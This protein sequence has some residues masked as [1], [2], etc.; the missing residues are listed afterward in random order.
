VGWVPLAPYEPYYPWYGRGYYG[1]YR[2]GYVDRSVHVT[3]VNIVNVYRNARVRD[4]ISGVDAGSFGRGRGNIARVSAEQI[5]EAGLVRGQLPVAP[6]HES[7]RYANHEARY[8]PREDANTRFYSRR[9]PAAVERVS[10]AEQQRSFDPQARRAAQGVTAQPG[11]VV[12]PAE[13]AGSAR[14]NGWRRTGDA[15]AART[16]AQPGEAVRRNEPADRGDGNWRRVGERTARPET[17]VPA[18]AQ[19][20]GAEQQVRRNEPADRTNGNWRRFGD[21]ATRQPE[22]AAPAAQ[23]SGEQQVRRNEPADRGNGNW[24]RFGEPAQQRQADRPARQSEPAQQNAQPKTSEP[25]RRNESSDRGRSWQRF[26]EPGAQSFTAPR[27]QEQPRRSETPSYS[28][29]SRQESLPIAP[30]VVRERSAPRSESY[31]RVQRSSGGGATPRVESAPRVERSGGGESRG[32]GARV[33][34]SEGGRAG[35]TR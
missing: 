31:S 32:G 5:R 10:F 4:G 29:P 34:R 23:R 19:R 20:S 25:V 35:R 26:G 13:A 16:A 3:N 7:L 22:T 17:V 11:R 12:Q 21:Q 33:S 27:A 18:A 30:P 28:R 8:T 1:G 9:Q 14:E 2:G 24:R 6:S 15:G